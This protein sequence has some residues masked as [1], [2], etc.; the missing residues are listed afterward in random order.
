MPPRALR[1]RRTAR[2]ASSRL[3]AALAGLIWATAAPAATFTVLNNN[4]FGPGSLAAA[5]SSSNSAAGNDTIVFDAALNGATINL[6]G[7]VM[8]VTGPLVIDAS[9]LSRGL[10]LNG[11]GSDRIFR[12]VGSSAA[13]EFYGLRFV[14]GNAFTGTGN[15]GACEVANLGSAGFLGCTF[16]DNGANLGGAIANQS[17]G[18]VVLD[19]CTFYRNV[20]GDSGALYLT[21]NSIIRN[22]TFTGNRSTGAAGT[23]AISLLGTAQ[24]AHV[25]VYENA[26]G[27]FG[28]GIYF[29]GSLTLDRCLVAGNTATGTASPDLF[30][31]GTV[32][33]GGAVTLVGN[34]GA[35][36]AGSVATDFPAG[37]RVG[38]P[39]SP[40]EARLRPLGPGGGPTD[41]LAPLA[42]SPALDAGGISPFGVDQRG[43]PRDVNGACD[44]GAVERGPIVTVT[45][46]ADSGPGSLRA[47]LAAVTAPDTRIQ[48]AAGLNGA[49]LTL[50]SGSLGLNANS[51]VEIDGSTL[52]APLTL[53]GGGLLRIFDLPSPA[54]LSLNRVVLAR[55]AATGGFVAGAILLG[56]SNSLLAV[57]C[58]FTGHTSTGLGATIGS[59]GGS[60]SVLHRCTLSDNVAV[61]SGSAIFVD[62]GEV[63]L[64]NCTVSGNTGSAFYVRNSGAVDLLHTTVT[65]NLGGGL[66][67]GLSLTGSARAR[68]ERSIIA[69]NVDSSAS[70]DIYRESGTLTTVSPNLVGNNGGMLT[71]NVSSQFPQGSLVGTPVAPL[72]PK[73]A[74]LFRAGG[75][76]ATHTL[77]AGSPALDAAGVSPLRLDQR[78]FPRS[79]NGA[80]D[81]GALER[82]PA[83]TVTS[84]GASGAGTLRQ[85]LLDAS[86]SGG[87]VILFD[88]SLNGASIPVTAGPLERT[89]GNVFV[90][91]TNLSQGLT[92]QGDGTSRLFACID[93]ATTIAFQRLRFSGG[94]E[95]ASNGGA[96]LLLD[97]RVGLFD[98][99]FED[100]SANLGGAIFANGTGSLTASGCTFARNVANDTGA[101]WLQCSGSSSLRNCTFSGNRCTGATGTGAVTLIDGTVT[102]THVTVAEN[103]GTLYGG[104]VY[105]A[106]LLTLD[107]C[108]LAGNAANAGISPDLYLAGAL[109][110]N[111][112]ASLLGSNGDGQSGSAAAAFA[113]GPLVGTPTTPLA[114]RLAPLQRRGG[115][116]ATHAL[117]ALSPALDAAG[118]SPLPVDQRG[119]PRGLGAASDLGAFERGP[120][121]TVLNAAA[122]G[123][124]SLREALLAVSASP[125]AVILFD[126]S[127]NAQSIPIGGSALTI[128]AGQVL[129]DASSLPQGLNLRG[130]GTTRLFEISGASTSVTLVRLR[131]FGGN[132][133]PGVIAGAGGALRSTDAAVGLIDC[134]FQDNRA[135]SGGA[136]YIGG[137]AALTASGCLFYR[138][139]AND[140]GGAMLSGTGTSDL[141][142]CTFTG[143]RALGSLGVG[144]LSLGSGP[145][146]LRHVTVYENSGSLNGGGV[147]V[148][149][150]LATIERC[151]IAANTAFGDISPDIYRSVDAIQTN[152]TPNLIG[153][154]GAGASEGSAA[155]N[156][157]GGLLVGT[158]ASPLDPRL[159]PLGPGGGP[160]A[161]LAPLT[162]SPALDAAGVS[163][164]AADQRGFP[165]GVNGA[166]DL[167]AVERG[168]VVTVTVVS[169]AGP[170]SLRDTLAAVTAPDTRIQFA[171]GLSGATI[172][173]TSA[174]LTPPDGAHVE[175]DGSTLSVPLTISG[176]DQF[177]I[178]QKAGSGSLSLNRLTLTKGRTI[179]IAGGAVL[180][181]DTGFL[182]VDCTF[183]GSASTGGVGALL[184]DA[185]ARAALHRC[186]ISNN[187]GSG[188]GVGGILAQGAVELSLLN[189]T[190]A[191]NQGEPNFGG[192]AVTGSSS[193]DL[194]HTTVTGNATSGAAGGIFLQEPARVRVERSLIAGNTG[195]IGSPDLFISGGTITA[196]APNLLGN[197]GGTSAGNVSA[198]FPAGP[199]V[200]TPAAPLDPKLGPLQRT[201]GSTA[202]HAPLAGSPALNATGD[203]ALRFDQR[204]LP[205]G[206][207]GAA[208]LGS[209]ERGPVLVV[210]TAADSGSGSLR[211]AVGLATAPDTQIVF[212]AGLNN[213]AISVNSPL[214]LGATQHLTVDASALAAGV[215]LQG[216]ASARL[217]QIPAGATLSLV[218]LGLT[219]G[220]STTFG[221]ALLNSGGTLALA[222]CDLFTN[223]A[224]NGGAI[225]ATAGNTELAGCRVVGNTATSSAAALGRSGSAVVAAT[226]CWFGTNLPGTTLFNAGVTFTPHLVFGV[227]PASANLNYGQSTVLTARFTRNTDASAAPLASL[228]PLLG[229][230]LTFSGP[231]NGTLSAAQTSLQANGTATATFTANFAGSGGASA[232]FDGVNA[233][234]SVVITT[235]P[236]S[237]GVFSITA[238]Q[239]RPLDIPFA[240]ILAQCTD[241]NGLNPL[242]VT[243]TGPGTGQGG[244]TSLQANAVRYT[245]PSPQFTG[246]DVASY[247]IRNVGG[248]T[249]SATIFVTVAA[250]IFPPGP[251][252]VVKTGNSVTATFNGIPGLTY[253]IETTT[254]LVSPAVWTPLN[255]PG[256]VVAD[257]NGNFSFTDP[258]ATT[259]KFYRA[260][261]Q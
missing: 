146:R 124:G 48:F 187:L 222:A 22:C 236:P 153:N 38:T 244:T 100:N 18:L 136:V 199:L 147:F 34:N 178:L 75:F 177:R 104:G 89:G 231:A 79:I 226:D 29:S 218:R 210:T 56:N 167:G 162:G 241:P 68:I 192:I 183:A 66:G 200:G 84:A 10:T 179:G 180:A 250:P 253:T 27:S 144:A 207:T 108:L 24:L 13:A 14:G 61:P 251:V 65:A 123:P 118:V 78:G 96:I 165:R 195:A 238:S 228:R 143:N 87:P 248:G 170:G 17:S 203:P 82:G 188:L 130:D 111:G 131:C 134:T 132:A 194:V 86:A 138:N 221:G 67:G 219:G 93:P 240:T 3:L 232:N 141:S 69:G 41:T 205:R 149:C 223:S 105:S 33:T 119:F 115:F 126:P 242:T 261:S 76:T 8:T 234:G 209:V 92:V 233:F 16:Q 230:A 140:A 121:T 128:A 81:L 114:A 103:T 23:G 245:P 112:A 6:A 237:A 1:P 235:P 30:K 32:T 256:S 62:S 9:S 154:N 168:P 55:G 101:L 46:A 217:W 164:F 214:V 127:L 113:A 247:T 213:A 122:S 98:C 161:T 116:T 202:T 169:D 150:T 4:A 227:S 157:P 201:G 37:P 15:G 51:T 190:V 129:I 20:A 229:R 139:E 45:V 133:G 224:A 42:G 5:V 11:N 204:G 71:G 246:L 53:S 2:F 94:R 35:G 135:T 83:L 91:A 171:A 148:A 259:R 57:D 155:A 12:V 156:F 166:S 49:T 225:F 142:N 99:T 193:L 80:S 198:F 26:G 36:G 74:P 58:S 97:A 64:V 254:S 70:P 117:L 72:D 215:R 257:S 109:F 110:T 212:A 63:A 211:E 106:S 197:N 182:A 249:A 181:Q 60:R 120:A 44:L 19:S 163:P 255:P 152:G 173:L 52:L 137:A 43:F 260:R 220:S 206:A 21:G 47:A 208:E 85:A 7:T 216:N 196:I 39:V 191:A 31:A 189:C 77:L 40:L 90:D 145:V 54:A 239:G 59:A 107:R 73:L 151:V 28:G 175:I 174:I 184:F 125:D 258:S 172:T 186:T 95:L 158:P 160:T 102:L 88:P 185:A 176:N 50:T 159:R 252:S 243:G 25:T